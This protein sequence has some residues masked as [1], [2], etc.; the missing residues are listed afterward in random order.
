MAST[1]VTLY[2]DVVFFVYGLSFILLGIVVVTRAK[3]ESRFELARFIWLLASFAFT[4]GV[5]EWMD[6]WEIERGYNHALALTKPCVLFVSYVFLFEFGRRMLRASL[7]PKTPFCPATLLLSPALLAVMVFAV[8]IA[9]GFADKKEL[10]LAIW[11]RYLLG[12]TGSQ[13]TGV[14]F[15][16]YCQNRIRPVLATSDFRPILHACQVAAFTFFVYGMLAG[17]IVP[18]A[19]WFPTFWLNNET[20][21]AF[22]G[23]PVELFRAG[24][25]ILM[26]LSVAQ[27]LWIFHIETHQR[28]LQDIT[29]RKQAQDDLDAQNKTLNAI[30]SSTQNAIVM[31]DDEG[32]ISFWNQGAAVMF[33]YAADE[34][35]GQILHELIA[36][37]RFLPAHYLALPVWQKT[38]QGNA[39]GKTL[40]LVGARKG[41]EEFPI[42]LSLSSV[43]FRKR[44]FAVGIIRDIT[45][46]KHQELELSQAK[47]AAETANR[48][49]S[50]FLANMSHEIRTP[51]NAILGLIQLVLE[52]PLKPKQYDF[53][54]K[55]HA[56]SRALLSI[57]ND[58][59]DYSKIEAGRLEIERLPFRIE[60][61]L[62]SV[63][64]LHTASI[65]EKYLEI[66]L[67]IDPTIPSEVIGDAMRL[68]QVLN[69]L[70]GNAIKFTESGEI[71]IKAELAHKVGEMITLRFAVRDTGIGLSKTQM[72]RLFQ[73]F[74]Q[75]DGSITR[76]HGGTG[77]GLTICERLVGLMGGAI[78]VSSTEGEGSTFAFT[79]QVG[80]GA[81]S[82]VG[83]SIH[84]L[85][86]RKI[87][88]V[89]DQ[90]T[91]R[92]ILKQILDAW[93]MET[94]I[95]ASG[96]EALAL[97]KEAEHSRCPFDAVFLDWRMPGMGGLEVAR[98]LQED[99]RLGHLT[100]PL[101]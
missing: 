69:N 68:T 56:S 54:H 90:E 25:G 37:E 89:D 72:D 76:K 93:G 6:L 59:L 50:E 78:S 47:L 66:F 45:T 14:G 10:A 2:L 96:E 52:T 85:E 65:T 57:L 4:H 95:A 63:A 64:D 97:I 1:T 61:T 87:L 5:L 62:K 101:L 40:E 32:K 21:D 70:V 33:G 3:E 18:R 15:L 39:I 20:F 73:A 35:I 9:I 44:W 82:I 13:L 30:T 49:K 53:L 16:L 28:L 92:I 41:G 12:F 99:A 38:G 75:G 31:M 27:L 58:I 84:P 46:R 8:L 67:E 55:A 83:H 36:P 79:I 94:H 71:H 91:A 22:V 60:E 80:L 26:L 29:E 100:H 23:L 34:A 17:L 43:F 88:A 51:M 81:N 19:M 77:L 11:S 48:A 24:C 98:H 74:T 7:E 86:Y 42:E